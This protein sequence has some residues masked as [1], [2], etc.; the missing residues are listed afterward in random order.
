M[1]EIWKDIPGY[2]KLYQGSNLGRI[3]S[4]DYIQTFFE[5]GTLCERL[6]KGRMLKT[7][8]CNGYVYVTL[9]KDGKEKDFHLHRLIWM[10]FNGKIP[11]NM[12]INHINEDKTDNRLENL[13]LM[14]HFDNM[15]WGTQITRR[16]EK[17]LQLTP[18]EELVK[19]WKSI[20]ELGRN[21]FWPS[22]VHKCCQGKQ[23]SHKGYIFRY[24]N[25]KKK[26][27]LDTNYNGRE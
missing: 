14:S 27:G 2:E 12:E 8:V 4:L 23:K 6:R 19:E 22:A 11:D 7:R 21:G 15:H 18:D 25:G 10:T 17:V 13:N 5:K 9:S 24:K 1:V 16:S 3:R 26:E 20:K